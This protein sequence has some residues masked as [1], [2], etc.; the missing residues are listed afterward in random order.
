MQRDSSHHTYL[1]EYLAGLNYDKRS[2]VV[3]RLALREK[4]LLKRELGNSTDPNAVVVERRGGVQIGYIRRDLAACLAPHMQPLQEPIQGTITELSS[5][6]SGSTC[7]VRI[8]FRVPSDWMK[9]QK[10]LPGPTTQTI[11]FCYDD[12]GIHRYVL[13]NCSEQLSSDVRDRLKSDGIQYSRCGLCYRPASDGR[14]YQWYIRISDSNNVNRGTIEEFFKRHFNAFPNTPE[15]ER[16][17]LDVEISVL[18]ES[19]LKSTQ[20]AEE[21]AGLAGEIDA[22][23]KRKIE[24]LQSALNER[25]REIQLLAD[26]K[27]RRSFAEKSTGR[28]YG[29]TDSQDS[30]YDVPDHVADALINVAGESLTPEQALVIISKL[31]PN[32]LEILLSA[33]NSAKDAKSFKHRRELLELL[34]TLATEYWGGLNN[35]RSDAEVRSVFGNHYA[36]TESEQVEKN[37]RARLRRTFNYNGRQVEMM[38]HLKIGFKQSAAETLRVHFEWDA[39]AKKIVI[40]HCGQH[41][42]QK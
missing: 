7:R 1:D 9:R 29:T 17:R 19:L 31:F 30:L 40:G 20:E 32:R 39:D 4:V 21:Y 6:L 38:K 18:R 28:L 8:R 10:G 25:E 23:G 37:Q 26:E 27:R 2:S 15:G 22:E 41:L 3:R 13:L 5:D 33:W 36:A 11:D 24:E 14:L 35:G 34:W 42:Y 12:S 16:D